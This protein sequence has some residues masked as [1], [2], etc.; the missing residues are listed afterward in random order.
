MKKMFML[1]VAILC[2]IV[3]QN[4]SLA[5]EGKYKLFQGEYVN[6]EGQAEKGI[7]MYNTETGEVFIFE[8]SYVPNNKGNM[9]T[10]H[11]SSI[12][13][14]TDYIEMLRKMGLMK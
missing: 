12:M 1:I 14:N 9:I 5:E 2:I 7:F 13:S 6:R 10:Q 4:L 3:M 8:D 11:W